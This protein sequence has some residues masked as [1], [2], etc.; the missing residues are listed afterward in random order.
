MSVTAHG[1]SLVFTSVLRNLVLQ[2]IVLIAGNMSYEKGQEEV[3]IT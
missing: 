1:K 3:F 2:S